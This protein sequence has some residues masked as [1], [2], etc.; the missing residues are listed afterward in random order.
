MRELGFFGL[1]LLLWLLREGGVG[2]GRIGRGWDG[3]GVG[4]GRIG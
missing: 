3:I 1:G 4:G 2:W